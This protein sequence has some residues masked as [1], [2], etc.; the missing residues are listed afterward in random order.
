[1]TFTT[2]CSGCGQKL[3]AKDHMAGK[4]VRCPACSEE[5]ELTPCSDGGE[6]TLTEEV[7]HALFVPVG[8]RDPSEGTRVRSALAIRG[9]L[10]RK[11]IREVAKVKCTWAYGKQTIEVSTLI[12]TV[13][14]NPRTTTT[15]GIRLQA[16]NSD[17]EDAGFA[18]ID[19]DE[20]QELT[21]AIKLIGELA[22]KCLDEPGDYTEL[23]YASKDDLRVGFY[24][25][26]SETPRQNAT[27]K[28]ISNRANTP[29][30]QQAFFATSSSADSVYLSFDDL[31][32][33]RNAVLAARRH[34]VERGA[35]D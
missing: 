5:V 27:N 4:R 7:S 34:L 8:A 15:F 30:E 32:E 6:P 13:L 3:E 22:K 19:F 21:D 18:F 24:Q 31:R 35:D 9:N 26:T 11:E 29:P 12:L 23:I 28:S 17:G 25:S 1:M 10:L 2:K 16:K 33:L 20:S 14:A